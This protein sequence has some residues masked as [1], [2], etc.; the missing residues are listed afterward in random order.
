[1]YGLYSNTSSSRNSI[2]TSNC[3]GGILPGE[4]PLSMEQIELMEHKYVCS[5]KGEKLF[6]SRVRPYNI[7]FAWGCYVFRVSR[8]CIH[9][10]SKKFYTYDKC[11][12]TLKPH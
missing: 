4:R 10:G 7:F 6:V 8:S 12:T 5:E 2:R 9:N 1:M 11:V 3:T